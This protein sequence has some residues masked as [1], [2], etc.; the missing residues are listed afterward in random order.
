MP[1]TQSWAVTNFGLQLPGLERSKARSCLCMPPGIFRNRWPTVFQGMKMS[2][3][4]MIHF[5]HVLVF[6]VYVNDVQ[7]NLKM[8]KIFYISFLQDLAEKSIMKMEEKVQYIPSPVI[9]G[10]YKAHRTTSSTLQGTVC[11]TKY[12]VSLSYHQFYCSFEMFFSWYESVFW[13]LESYISFV[14]HQNIFTC[15]WCH[16]WPIL[17]HIVNFILLL[18]ITREPV[19]SLFL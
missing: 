11:A 1:C 17:L 13:E 9:R 10:L 4:V 16:Y 2:L 12:L 18:E 7:K 19:V 6:T 15:P 14:S 8:W 5:V 3:M